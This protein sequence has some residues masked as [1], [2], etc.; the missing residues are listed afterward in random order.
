MA[1]GQHAACSAI[2]GTQRLWP[3]SA[4]IPHRIAHGYLKAADFLPGTTY[5]VANGASASPSGAAT[6]PR[7]ATTTR[8]SDAWTRG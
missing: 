3:L 8:P 7:L 4:F 6:A 1:F 5:G 2:G